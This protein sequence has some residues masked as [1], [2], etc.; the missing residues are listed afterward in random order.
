ME[1]L[2]SALDPEC[3]VE[4]GIG[5]KGCKV[6][7]TDAPNPRLVV[8]FDKPGALLAADET[9]CDY[10]LIA[11]SNCQFN[12][13]AP[14]ELKRG[15]LHADRVVKQLQAGARAAEKLVP[16]REAVRFRPIAVSGSTSKHERDKL[17]NKANRVR[18]RGHTEPIRLMSCGQGLARVLCR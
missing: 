4:R 11:Q 1:R 14:L 17:K 3:L 18:F 10:L 9:R 7:M 16:Q 6:A 15:R 2:R 12:W 13:V 8:D 5:K